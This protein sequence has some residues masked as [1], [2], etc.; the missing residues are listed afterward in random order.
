MHDARRWASVLAFCL[1]P[2]A[3][4][5]CSKEPSIP[6]TA[7][8]QEARRLPVTPAPSRGVYAKAETDTLGSAAA[9]N[10]PDRPVKPDNNVK[11]QRDPLPKVL[12]TTG[13]AALCRVGVGDAMPAMQLTDLA[14][15]Q[16]ELASLF[17]ERL[18][19]VCFWKGD[20]ALARAELIDLGPDVV[21]PYSDQGVA[22]VGIAVE[23]SADRVRQ[24]V[25]EGS[26]GFPNLLDTDGSSLSQ[27]GSGRLPRTYLLDG[28][29]QVLW[30]DIEYSSSS[31]R[32]LLQSIRT[33][34]GDG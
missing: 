23:E 9:L 22:V 13:H 2:V 25:P 12:L 17:G 6:A 20:R 8:R 16:Q 3:V 10:K 30:F 21:E 27:V 26:E 32:E 4:A 15:Q 7:P 24:L 28:S 31:R 1:W 34:L 11:L 33:L 14:G 5:G 29:G 18:T 19:V